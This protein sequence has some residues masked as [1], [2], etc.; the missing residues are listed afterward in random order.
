MWG[1]HNTLTL[2]GGRF[3]RPPNYTLRFQEFNERTLKTSPENKGLKKPFV[4]AFMNGCKWVNGGGSGIR[5]HGT[6]ACTTVFETVPFN[7]SG[8]PPYRIDQTLTVFLMN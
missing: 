7:R 8:I 5:T 4:F 3:L 6:L 1:I 2:I